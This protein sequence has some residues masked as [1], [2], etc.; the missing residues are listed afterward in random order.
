MIF[1]GFDF[2]NHFCEWMFNNNYDKYPYFEYNYEKYPNRDQQIN[3]INAYIDEYKNASNYLANDS[4]KENIKNF[5]M[6]D[7]EQIIKEGNSFALM[8]HIIWIYWAIGKAATSKI[9][10]EYLVKFNLNKIEIFNSNNIMFKK[11]ALARCDAYFKLKNVFF[12]NGY[13]IDGN[14]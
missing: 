11:Y 13:E 4:D 3:L 9:K 12:P 14:L 10:F 6:L 1:R 2:G 5:N 7:V 8:A